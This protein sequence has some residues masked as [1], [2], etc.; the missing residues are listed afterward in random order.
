MTLGKESLANRGGG[1]KGALPYIYSRAQQKVKRL[2]HA[3]LSNTSLISKLIFFRNYAAKPEAAIIPLRNKLIS[4][5]SPKL[6][7]SP[8]ERREGGESE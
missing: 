7:I 5:L 1:E 8:V 2:L 3:M 6:L 4:L